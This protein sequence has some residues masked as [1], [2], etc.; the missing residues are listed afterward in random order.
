[1]AQSIAG[2]LRSPFVVTEASSQVTMGDKVHIAAYGSQGGNLGERA[3]A[4]NWQVVWVWAGKG[5]SHHVCCCP[6]SEGQLQDHPW[7]L[8]HDPLGSARNVSVCEF[9]DRCSNYSVL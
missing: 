6:L 9:G 8:W 3:Q 1:M 5:P 7:G 4:G 2:L